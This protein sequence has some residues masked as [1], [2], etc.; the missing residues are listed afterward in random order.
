MVFLNLFSLEKYISAV[1]VCT[2]TMLQLGLPHVN[3]LTKLDQMKLFSD[4]LDFNINFY[5]E[6]L[7]LNYLVDKLNDDNVLPELVKLSKIC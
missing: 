2:I 6:V 5:T 4:K 7:D 3:V 1:M